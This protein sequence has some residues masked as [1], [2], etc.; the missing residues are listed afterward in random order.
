AAE[1]TGTGI[2]TGGVN[3]ATCLPSACSATEIEEIYGKLNVPLKFKES[4]CQTKADKLELDGGD[5]AMIS[6]LSI[7]C[8][9][10]IASTAY[11]VIMMYLK[12]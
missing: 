8:F 11:D 1:R 2:G 6:F 5:I 7:V 12:K 3:L 4:L 10:M 9:L